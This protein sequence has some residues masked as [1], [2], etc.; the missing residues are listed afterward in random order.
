[1]LLNYPTQDSTRESIYT[2]AILLGLLAG[3]LC[4]M[5]VRPTIAAETRVVSRASGKIN[6]LPITAGHHPNAGL[7]TGVTPFLDCVSIIYDNANQGFLTAIFG[8]VSAN[9]ANVNIPIGANNFFSPNPLDEGQPVVFFP[10]VNHNVFQVFFGLSQSTSITWNLLGQTVTA[11]ND[12]ALY[13]S[14]SPTFTYQGRLT[15]GSKVANGTYDLQFTLYDQLIE[16]S[17]HGSLTKSGVTV[18]GGIFTTQLD[19]GN[20]AIPGLYLEIGA[21]RS[22]DTT[23]TTLTPRQPIYAAPFATRS[24]LAD[25]VVSIS[26]QS[27][28]KVALATTMVLSGNLPSGSGNYVQ[29]TTTRQAGSNFNISGN[30]TIGGNL[31]VTGT[32]NA[33]LPAGS[34][35]YIQ[36]TTSQ[37]AGSNFNVSGNGTV[38][39]TL[40]GN[41]VSATTSIGIGTTAPN[42]KLHIVDSNFP[43][44]RIDGSH[45]SGT[46]LQLNNT[47]TGG[48]TW[49]ILSSASGNSEGAG[50]LVI[51]DSTGG[52]KVVMD[53]PL[54]VLSCTGCTTVTSDRYAKSNITP[55]NSRSVLEKLVGIPIQTWNYKDDKAGVRHIGPMAQDFFAAFGLGSDD[56]HI[57]L[58]DEGGVALAAIQELYRANQAKD[59]QI[60]D[61][62]KR[63]AELEKAIEKLTNRK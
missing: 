43:T 35:N 25:S 11:S 30:G 31:T 8:Y 17:Q 39:G 2:R 10:G 48:H 58:L 3:A 45:P 47:A 61:L 23:F 40:S 18:T 20:T 22:G 28:D 41:V 26:G 29:N 9:T 49:S 36:N 14:P 63:V 62:T 52:G 57:N 60:D 53:V 59:K 5:T 38:G 56:K 13:C 34:A 42:F 44:M 46:W 24:V 51:A 37:Q 1:M 32:L 33:A 16:G 50:N 15:D 6:A 27:P 21:K 54:Q 7:P 19:F 4:F 55:V 12:P